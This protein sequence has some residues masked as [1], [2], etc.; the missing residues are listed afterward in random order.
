MEEA[1][2]WIGVHFASS[3]NNIDINHNHIIKK[4]NVAEVISATET[5]KTG[6]APSVDGIE[7]KFFDMN[8]IEQIIQHLQL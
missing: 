6:K 5:L 7:D 2:K 1:Q 4:I 8:N 3:I